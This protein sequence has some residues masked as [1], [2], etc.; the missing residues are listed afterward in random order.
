MLGVP[1]GLNALPEE[2]PDGPGRSPAGS[3]ETTCRRPL[4]C[5]SHPFCA[6]DVAPGGAPQDVEPQRRL[7]HI[8]EPVLGDLRFPVRLPKDDIVLVLRAGADD[9]QHHVGGT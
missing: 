2:T 9:L 3:T 4:I 5:S 8:D 6:P 1:G 7:A